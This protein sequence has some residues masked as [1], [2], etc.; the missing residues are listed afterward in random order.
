MTPRHEWLWD[1]N[2]RASAAIRFHCWRNCAC[3]EPDK[4]SGR[5]DLTKNVWHIVDNLASYGLFET[6]EY[7]VK[8]GSV[9]GGKRLRS[10]REILPPQKRDGPSSAGTCGDDGRQFCIEPWPTDLLGPIATAPPNPAGLD[11]VLIEDPDADVGRCGNH[12][13]GQQDCFVDDGVPGCD[14]NVLDKEG[15]ALYGVDPVFPPDICLGVASGSMM[16]TLGGRSF[17]EN[18]SAISRCNSTYVSSKCCGSEDG[19]I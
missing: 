3:E 17:E 9:T 5:K 14:C 12:C 18:G 15:I 16:G 10:G 4:T 13:T 6:K 19:F 11:G 8:I 2:F 7:G 1:T